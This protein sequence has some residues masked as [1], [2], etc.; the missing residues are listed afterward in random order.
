MQFRSGHIIRSFAAA[1]L[2][3]GMTFGQVIMLSPREGD[4]TKLHRIAVT[5]AGKAGAA[6]DLFINDEHAATGEFRIDGK[7][8]FLNIPVPDGPVNVRVDAVGSRGRIFS[9]NRNMH[10]LGP[11]HEVVSLE[12]NLECVADGSSLKHVEL[13]I[14]DA[15][16]FRL[17]HLKIASVSIT[18]GSIAEP[19]FDDMSAGHQL[20]ID[21]G[22]LRV[23][24]KAPV[25]PG[26][27]V[28]EVNIDGLI[29]QFPIR[30]ARPI[31]PLILTGFANG[32]LMSNDD[33]FE[34]YELAGQDIVSRKGTI[35]D[36]D[37]ASL[38][39]RTAFYA[40]G[41]FLEEYRVTA[42]FDSD[43]KKQNQLED[44][45][46][47]ASQYSLYGDAG[48]IMYDVQTN[49][50]LFVRVENDK[51]YAVLGDYRTDL[52][53]TE[54][55]SY[56]RTL[57][58]LYTQYKS[59][60]FQ[61]TGFGAE[62]DRGMS[63]KRIRG[64]GISGF[65][66]LG[67][68]DITRFSDKVVLE[69][70]DK[71]HSEKVLDLQPMIRYHDYDI[72]YEDGTLFF[73]QPVP[74]IDENGNPVTIVVSYEMAH[75]G[76]Q[77]LIGGMRIKGRI[78]GIDLGTTLVAE[79]Q[80]PGN[81]S[82]L[83]LDVRAPVN[84]WLTV[85]AELAASKHSDET[86]DNINGLA[87]KTEFIA[88]PQD[89]LT[90]EGYYR[91]VDSSFVNMSQNS[92]KS[93][94]DT[95]KY[96]VSASYKNMKKGTLNSEFW[97]EEKNPGLSAETTKRVFTLDYEKVLNSR[98]SFAVGFENAYRTSGDE[99]SES[100]LL[101]GK[102]SH[103][104]N[105]KLTGS[106]EYYQN[107]K[108]E[109][110]SKP[111]SLL[112]GMGW[113]MTEKIRLF[114]KHRIIDSRS[115]PNETVFG[116]ESK[117]RENTD[118]TGKYEMGGALGEDRAKATIGLRNKWTVRPDLTFN[119]A[120]ENTATIDSFQT[121]TQDHNA[122]SMAYEYLP[123]APYKSSGKFEHRQDDT[124]VK[125]VFTFG[126]SMRLFQ[127]FSGITRLE[128]SHTDYRKE[129][130]EEVVKGRYQFGIAYRPDQHDLFTV[131]AKLEYATE[132]N[133]HVNPDVRS[134]R[135]I[136]STHGYYQPRQELEFGVRAA[137]RFVLEE[138]GDL[139]DDENAVNYFGLRTEYDW[140]TRWSTALDLRLLNMDATNEWEFG[141]ALEVNYLV[142][143]NIQLGAGYI[144]NRYDD[145]DFSQLDQSLSRFYINFNVKFSETIF[146]WR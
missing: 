5:V 80:E 23:P 46:D 25:K 6:A 59:G 45:D 101:T 105:D 90:L 34:D 40:R 121:A 12:E 21:S 100:S 4:V 107:L 145:P 78:S 39:G 94:R 81:Y 120:F 77:N 130:S 10:I 72:D 108:S 47:P 114:F 2:L 37:H 29:Q 134:D 93:E 137:R 32:A 64:E 1:F 125:K 135:L 111:T 98:G 119:L 48:Q 31:E 127:G 113:E 69:T 24:I 124:T 132:R 8:D 89:D 55:A 27:A 68:T 122:V 141:N 91:E 42:S 17:D 138:E 109:D 84:D 117:V 110:Q 51:A 36:G 83:G 88:R 102:Y 62:T 57:N 11:A 50:K 97:Q 43:R 79:E 133:S 30:F 123:E 99:S 87:Y 142:Y 33:G 106:L 85:R 3:L 96:G 20:A 103:K 16:G 112:L 65:Y 49:S 131:L 129:V 75:D 44:D 28:I 18:S 60:A 53:D 14:R 71:Y 56:N 128:H 95:R 86:D 118:F 74:S 13:E 70:R 73:K 140:T 38:R 19:D 82:L 104:L 35:L 58:G 7:L 136:F 76:P 61:V 15:W 54:F 67:D 41:T 143:K 92:G 52:Q 126:G 9:V 115:K 139:F 26:T 116:F 22:I 63:L 144:F 66:Y 146:D